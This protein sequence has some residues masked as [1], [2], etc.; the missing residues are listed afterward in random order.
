M[1]IEPTS[2]AWKAEGTDVGARWQYVL[3]GQRGRRILTNG[4]E[5]PRP[6]DGRA[7]ERLEIRS[8]LPRPGPGDRRSHVGSTRCRP[9]P[10][11]ASPDRAGG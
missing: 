1:G 11:T 6:R 4:D 2:S 10:I 9:A 8:M 7:M 3:A 5:R